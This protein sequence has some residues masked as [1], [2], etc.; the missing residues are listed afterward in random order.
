MMKIEGFLKIYDPSTQEVFADTHN[1]IHSENMS[2]ALANTLGDRGIGWLSELH[3]GNG[4]TSVDTTGVI[5]YLPPNIT[6]SN[7][8]LYNGTYYKIIDDNSVLNFDPINNKI[9][10]RHTP[11]LLYTDIFIT[12]LLDYGEPAGQQAFDNSTD[13]NGTYVFDEIGFKSYNVSENSGLLLTHA[14]F[15]PVQKSLNRLLQIDYTIRIQTLTDLS[16]I[17]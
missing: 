11:G 1:A 14:I 9:Q 6:G 5:T 12:C 15:S 4:G 8:D 17:L 10:I 13:F 2:V 7:A 16:T 3:F